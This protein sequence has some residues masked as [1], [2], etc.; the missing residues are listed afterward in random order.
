MPNQDVSEQN[1]IEVINLNDASLLRNKLDQIFTNHSNNE[2]E[3]AYILKTPR[4]LDNGRHTDPLTLA[5]SNEALATQLL[6]FIS[7]L[8]K[9]NQQAIFSTNFP[10][11]DYFPQLAKY[12]IDNQLP[13]ME[14]ILK[15]VNEHSSA[16]SDIAN[17]RKNTQSPWF[18]KTRATL[19]NIQAAVDDSNNETMQTAISDEVTYH[20][21]CHEHAS[22]WI[23][24]NL[25]S[26]GTLL[27]DQ[28]KTIQQTQHSALE[29]NSS[30]QKQ[31]KQNNSS[32]RQLSKSPFFIYKDDE[33]KELRQPLL[34]E[35]TQNPKPI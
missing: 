32:Y 3:I 13:I 11:N 28:L 23:T 16:S 10:I 15:V 19:N 1:L 20:K 26:L 18:L 25:T 22:K 30:S 17:P 33:T 14:S 9:D 35:D 29:T 5:I 27:D 31:S 24:P 7:Y 34:G 2:A 12:A 4:T 8:K 21:E 6:I